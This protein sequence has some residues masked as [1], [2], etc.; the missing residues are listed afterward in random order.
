MGKRQFLISSILFFSMVISD[1][2]FL[3]EEVNAATAE[4]NYQWYCAQCHNQNGDGKGINATKDMPTA[5][6]NLTNGEDLKKFTDEQIFN[7]ITHGGPANTL[8]PGMPPWGDILT[9]DE[10]KELIKHVRV[11]CN[12]KGE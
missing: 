4:E 1:A 11:L 12:C 9:P 2:M 5:P 8:S 10:I 7:T 6:R 3:T